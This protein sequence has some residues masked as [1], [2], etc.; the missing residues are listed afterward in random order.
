MS[1]F[2]FNH[3]TEEQENQGKGCL[4]QSV[5]MN[6]AVFA[7]VFKVC[8]YEMKAYVPKGKHFFPMGYHV[9]F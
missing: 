5:I 2:F 6:N 7:D 4:G 9:W 3:L 8:N 1:F